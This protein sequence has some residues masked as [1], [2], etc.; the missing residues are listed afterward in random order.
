[1]KKKQYF[2]Q[3]KRDR[4]SKNVMQSESARDL[5]GAASDM[6]HGI[7]GRGVIQDSIIKEVERE[8]CGRTAS[9]EGW[10]VQS[11]HL[12]HNGVTTSQYLELEGA[13]TSIKHQHGGSTMT[14][15]Y[16]NL[17][18]S[19]ATMHRSQ[20]TRINDLPSSDEE[21]NRG[22]SGESKEDQGGPRWSKG[23]PGFMVRA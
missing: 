3:E 4:A 7:C 15:G 17:S 9:S 8:D 6:S 10:L 21:W 16:G 12:L 13:I 5:L 19:H 18:T 20:N 2:N 14:V 1:M 22:G 11:K 23:N